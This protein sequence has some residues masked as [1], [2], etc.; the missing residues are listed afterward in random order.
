MT[1]GHVNGIATEYD[2]VWSC[3]RAKEKEPQDTMMHDHVNGFGHR[4]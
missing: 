3:K 1:H 2:D 4:A